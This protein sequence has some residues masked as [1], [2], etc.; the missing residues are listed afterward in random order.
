MKRADLTTEAVIRAVFLYGFDAY[1]ELCQLYP[2]KVV[3]AAFKRDTDRRYLT[4]GVVLYRPFLTDRGKSKLAEMMEG[5][6]NEDG[7]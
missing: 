4:Y 5:G 6:T 1:E 7:S 2:E 3:L